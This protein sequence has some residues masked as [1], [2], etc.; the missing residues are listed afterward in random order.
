MGPEKC[1]D[2][3][4]TQCVLWSGWFGGGIVSLPFWKRMTWV[5]RQ[6]SCLLVCLS[7]SWPPVLCS[8]D[9]AVLGRGVCSHPFD[10]QHLCLVSAHAPPSTHGGACQTLVTSKQP[11]RRL[12]GR[13]PRPPRLTVASASPGWLFD[14]S[15]LCFL[16][17]SQ[18]CMCF[19][20]GMVF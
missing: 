2:S 17:G 5:G 20:S 9:S 4:W 15:S 14:P 19:V 8:N 16:C 12:P 1:R 6:T 13:L 11:P 3:A 18:L 7:L 10:M